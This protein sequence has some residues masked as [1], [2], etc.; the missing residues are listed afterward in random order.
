MTA[1]IRKCPLCRKARNAQHSPFC[2][3]ACKDR[4]LLNWLADGYAV[5]GPPADMADSAPDAGED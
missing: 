4:D 3:K 2:S 1:S 5:P